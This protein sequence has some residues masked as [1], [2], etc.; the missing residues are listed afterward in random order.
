[1][2]AILRMLLCVIF[3][4]N[5]SIAA[6]WPTF[7]ADNLRSGKSTETGLLQKWP[8]GGP[9]LL[10]SVEGKLGSGWSGCAVVDD[11]VYT[12]GMDEG[13]QMGTIYAMADGGN[14]LWQKE[15]GKEWQR[16]FRGS[17]TTPT[18]VDDKVYIISGQ[19][20]V[21]CF[22]KKT[23]DIVWQTDVK[24]NYQVRD[25][26][27]G[28]SESPLVYDGKVFCSAGGSAASVVALDAATGK[29]AWKSEAFKTGCAYV[30]PVYFDHNGTKTVST[31]LGDIAVGLDI[32]TGKTLWS[33]KYSDYET[34][35]GRGGD[36]RANSP[37]YIDGTLFF[38]SGY[39]SGALI[40]KLSQDGKSIK[41]EK[42]IPEFDNHHHGVVYHDGYIYGTNWDGNDKGRW[43]CVDLAAQTIKYEADWDLEKSAVVFADN[44]IYG[45][46]EK[47]GKVCLIK[48][49]P[50][51]L[52]VVSEFKVTQGKGQHWAHP[53][54][55]NGKL[56]IRHGDSLM[57]YKIK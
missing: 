29:E 21:F 44:L 23:G 43:I 42:Y 14:I 49:D 34:A 32:A 31:L 8:E 28:F 12:V 1:M 37:L 16:A 57:V 52:E 55:S 18:V 38:T 24:N 53:A 4:A 22:D 5:I 51:K 54:I 6:D 15:Y 39:G 48:P 33:F 45:Y 7:R 25:P 50:E 47:S 41:V 20:V 9:E 56:Y 46:Q 2:T 13:T 19:L 27:F 35:G 30:S 40:A 11:V 17:R 3:L 36:I 26:R 10:W